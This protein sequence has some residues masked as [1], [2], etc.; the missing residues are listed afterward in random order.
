[1]TTV[2]GSTVYVWGVLSITTLVFSHT[3]TPALELRPLTTTLSSWDVLFATKVGQFGPKWDKSW[4][5]ESQFW[6]SFSEN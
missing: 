4:T 1:M 6:Y 3:L 5:F 2:T